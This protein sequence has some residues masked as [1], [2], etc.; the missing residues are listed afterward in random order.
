M[1]STV[2]GHVFQW[3]LLK[4][5]D[6]ENEQLVPESILSF[7]QFRESS[8][9]VDPIISSIEYEVKGMRDLLGNGLM[10]Y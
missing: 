5:E 6:A 8:Y 2:R 7:V 3:T 1:F 9:S 10:K 4:D